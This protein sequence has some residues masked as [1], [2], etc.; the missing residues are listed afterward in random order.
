MTAEAVPKG[1]SLRRT[2]GLTDTT[3]FLV[4]AVVSPRWIASAA[5]AGPSALVIWLIA[6]AGFFVPMAW[7][8]IELSSRHPDEGGIYVW[9]RRAFGDFAGFMTGWMYWASNLVYFPGLLYFAVGNALLIAGPGG[10]AL[11]DSAAW[12]IGASLVALAIALVL[13]LV[14]LGVGKW[15]H[16]LGGVATWVPVALLVALAA[17]AWMRGGTA[18]EF[19]P[20]TLA[21]ATGLRD[22]VFWSTIAFAF[23]GMEAASMLGGEIAAAKRNIPRAIL[24]SG[25]V[26]TAIYV[27]GTAAVLVTL[28]QREVSALQGFG[29]AI[30]RAGRVVGV[31]SAGVIAALFLTISN[32]GGV[33]AWLTA[34][35]RL[36][37]VAGLDRYLPPAFAWLHPRWGTPVVALLVQAAG[38]AVFIVLGQAGATVKGAYDV[39]VGM[40]VIVYFIPYLFMFAAY[41]RLQREPAGPEVRRTPGGSPVAILLGVVGFATTA[42]SI[43]LAVVPPSDEQHPTLAVLKIVGSSLALVVLGAWLYSRGKARRAAT[44]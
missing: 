10:A 32:I 15:L 36:P 2:M 6:L 21:P 29:Q 19:T 33:G 35:A 23:S 39:L 28:P 3:L 34:A 40:G 8:V 27:L 42:I 1:G 26:I 44:T 18:T 22:I 9:T 31:P 11:N 14:G 13:N 30:E 43:V 38:T 12:Y 7:A 41:I 4:V 24:L 17:A 25:A 20:A 5:A 16:N 37:F